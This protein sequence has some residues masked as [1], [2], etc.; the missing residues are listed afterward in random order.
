M[1]GGGKGGD[2][3][4]H[5]ISRSVEFTRQ[6]SDI[7]G[8]LGEKGEVTFLVCCPGGGDM[9]EGRAERFMIRLQT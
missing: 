9:V 2:W 8:K 5:G 7:G 1:I 4:G 6:V 3:P